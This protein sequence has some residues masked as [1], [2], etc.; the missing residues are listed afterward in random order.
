MPLKAILHIPHSSLDLPPEYLDQF[1]I[2]E[3]E[4]RREA[5]L[6]ADLFTDELFQDENSGRTTILFPV[7]RLLVD[8]E[9][10]LDDALEA[11]ARYGLGVIYTHTPWGI[12]L[13]RSL[14][15]S[16][17]ME[18]LDRYYHPHQT[19]LADAVN[20][21]LATAGAALIIDCHSFPKDPY[22]FQSP[23]IRED[24]EICLGTDDAHTP[25]RLLQ[26]VSQEFLRR[27]YRLAW[28]HPYS[29]SM[30]PA[31]HFRSDPNVYSLMI[32]VRRDLILDS[33]L[34]HKSSR[35]EQVKTDVEAAI[36]A[37]ETESV[38]MTQD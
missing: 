28:N 8:V 17:R 38:S 29:G 30:V 36:S 11:G 37:A 27:G 1:L 24:P 9:R 10:F 33:S 3:D 15:E 25:A 19:R 20:H 23:S 12:P 5:M 34:E 35:F 7:S 21:S 2:P 13:R 18:L 32:E 22:P 31:T 16:E 4:L 26:I 6:V 14:T